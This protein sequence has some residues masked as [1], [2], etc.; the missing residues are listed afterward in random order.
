VIAPEP[1]QVWEA[2]AG[3]GCSAAPTVHVRIEGFTPNGLAVYG[4]NERASGK[5]HGRAIVA[6]SMLLKRVS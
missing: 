5:W 2:H 1:G 6:V 3:Y 4:T